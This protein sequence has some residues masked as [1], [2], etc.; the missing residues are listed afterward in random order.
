MKLKDVK[1]FPKEKHLRGYNTIGNLSIEL[2]E[3]KMANVL[4][5]EETGRSWQSCNREEK[6]Y[7]LDLVKAI[8]DAG[9]IRVVKGVRN[10]YGI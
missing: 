5:K 8:K 3:G 4:L 9:C 2:D 1:G 6:E 7:W 10:E